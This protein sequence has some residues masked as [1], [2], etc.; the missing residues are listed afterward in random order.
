[1]R[2]A[3]PDNRRGVKKFGGVEHAQAGETRAKKVCIVSKTA[4]RIRNQQPPHLD[5]GRT[6]A[7]PNNCL[8]IRRHVWGSLAIGG[9][10]AL[11]KTGRGSKAD[12]VL[13][14]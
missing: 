1:M 6:S 11:R 2:S 4:L 13:D 7:R 3:I 5:R 14:C 10:E 8:S 9:R 12:R